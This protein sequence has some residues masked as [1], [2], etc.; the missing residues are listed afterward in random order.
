MHAADETE[1]GRINVEPREILEGFAAYVH[2]HDAGENDRASRAGSDDVEERAFERYGR[3]Q[4][5]GY[6]YKR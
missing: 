5:A 6:V 2:V 1:P 4:N 3:S